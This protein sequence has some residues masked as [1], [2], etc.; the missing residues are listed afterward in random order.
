MAENG[1]Q[2]TSKQRQAALALLEHP[3]PRP[4]FLL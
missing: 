4:A 1:T 3:I 2:L